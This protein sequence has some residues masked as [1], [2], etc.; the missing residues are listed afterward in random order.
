MR[1]SSNIVQFNGINIGVISDVTSHFLQRLQ[2]VCL[3]TMDEEEIREREAAILKAR[4]NLS[5][6]TLKEYRDIFSFFDR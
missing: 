3:I 2:F 5:D 4:E 1:E 6:E